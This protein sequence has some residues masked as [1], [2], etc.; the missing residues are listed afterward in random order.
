MRCEA[1][2][3]LGL[4]KDAL[5]NEV[6]G[7]H[8]LLAKAWQPENF[9]DEP[10]LKEAAE[11]KLKDI[12]TAFEFLTL[13]STDR[14]DAQRPVYLSSSITDASTPT[15]IS[16]QVQPPAPS[17]ST[18]P[19]NK[20]SG[21]LFKFTTLL[22]V[23]IFAGSIITL[24]QPQLFAIYRDT[25]INNSRPLAAPMANAEP[26]IN[27]AKKSNEEPKSGYFEALMQGLKNLVSPSS[28]PVADTSAPTASQNGIK[29]Q[30][31]SPLRTQHTPRPTAPDSNAP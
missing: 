1:L 3:V 31:P 17:E 12:E 26:Q 29:P 24:I 27:A 18:A 13:T 25:Q 19:V 15:A 10:K 9:K 22:F 14:A 4:G 6:R 30:K 11:T 28:T 8:R 21:L 20:R 7:A 2:H 23:L 5:E 16:A